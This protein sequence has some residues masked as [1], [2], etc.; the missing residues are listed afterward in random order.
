MARY[1]LNA[2]RKELCRWLEVPRSVTY[3]KPRQGTPGVKPS[4]ETMTVDGVSVSNEDVTARIRQLIDT[5]FNAFGYEYITHELKKE[6]IINKK[7]VYRLMLAND[8]LLGKMIRPAGKRD[9]VQFRRIEATKP[10]EYLCWDIKYIWIN[11]ERRNYY[12]LCIL[13]VFTRKIVDWIFQSSIRQL[14]LINLLRRVNHFHQL[15]GVVL[16]NDNGSQF[17]ANKVRNFLKNSEV[18]QEFTHVATP[19]ENSYIEAFHS[20]LEREVIERNEFASYYEAKETLQRFIKHY[21]ER[22]LHRSIGFT[23]PQKKWEEAMP[24]ALTVLEEVSN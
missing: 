7:K 14:D 8:L 18:R 1:Q 3:Y 22:R 6:Y 19:E 24:N 4:R 15:Q 9:F 2:T 21:N 12:L 5:E 11:G 10:L 16:R 17:I 20:I 13:D 23:T